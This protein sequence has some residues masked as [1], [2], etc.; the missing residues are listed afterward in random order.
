VSFEAIYRRYHQ[1]LYRYCL[2][3]LGN[4]EDAQDALQ[5]TM[6]K[7]MRAL[8]GE[9]RRID[10][11]PWLYR[12]AHNESIELLRRRRPGEEIDAELAAPG[13]DAAEMA[14]QRERLAR[15]LADLE[16]L[17]ER[18]RGALLMRE[19]AGLGFEQIGAALKASPAAA[20]QAV[21]EA[22]LS[23][24]Q[25]AEGREMSCREAMWELSEADGRVR[26]RRDIQAHLRSC[27]ECRA[28]QEEIERRHRD[29]AAL[30][31]LPAAAAAGLLHGILGSAKASGAGAAGGAGAAS[32]G[33][34]AVGTG[35][36]G[37]AGKAI[38]GSVIAKSVAAVA[39]AAVVG[40]SAA[41]RAGLVHVLPAGGGAKTS[42]A[43]P[44]GTGSGQASSPPATQ[45]SSSA[46]NG[47]HTRGAGSQSARGEG[48]RHGARGQHGAARGH[49]VGSDKH[50]AHPLH[51]HNPSNTPQHPTGGKRHEAIRPSNV[52][53]GGAGAGGGSGHGGGESTQR[54]S[55]G[56]LGNGA[57]SD[58]PAGGATGTELQPGTSG[59]EG[60]PAGE[61]EGLRRLLPE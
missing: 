18:Q 14:A 22:R 24:R 59:A 47:A 10:L 58:E 26:R 36:A 23:L 25:M 16:E 19:L 38:A 17:P 21:Y 12:V 31:P 55:T 27:P 15:L 34:G 40:V 48:H 11:K 50:A 2:A 29:L 52:G 61:G 9:K 8:P 42:A 44:A 32:S 5:N 54:G 20:R 35:A 41:D 1:Q 30:A 43:T 33:A 37:A 7:A 56:K 57:P 49:A 45:A 39:V 13:P 28:F 53:P 4:R 51:G 6:V 60:K 3:I 46:A